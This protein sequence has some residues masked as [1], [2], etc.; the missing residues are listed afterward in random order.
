[1][2]IHFRHLIWRK[3]ANDIYTMECGL[4]RGL[5]LQVTASNRSRAAYTR[6]RFRAARETGTRSAAVLVMPHGNSMRLTPNP[7]RTYSVE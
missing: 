3:L 4:H 5:N 7:T 6:A 1:M 2:G